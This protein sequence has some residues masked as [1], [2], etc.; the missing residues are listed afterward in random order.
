MIDDDEIMKCLNAVCGHSG[1]G[2]SARR[3]GQGR[4]RQGQHNGGAGK[5]RNE[6]FA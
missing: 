3:S 6:V 2:R 5:N 4:R 1:C